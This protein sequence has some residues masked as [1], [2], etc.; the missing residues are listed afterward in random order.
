MT[1]LKFFCSAII[2]VAIAASV[3]LER[4]TQTK[5]RENEAVLRQQDH[6]F[7][8]LA[9]ENQRLYQRLSDLIAQSKTNRAP[10]VDR[11]TELVQLRAKV[12]ALRIQANQLAK[13][14]AENRRLTG[15]QYLSLGQSNLPGHIHILADSMAMASFR[16]NGK[17]NDASALA[18]A[19]LRYTDANQGVFPLNLNQVEPYLAKASGA[20]SPLTGTNDFEVAFQGSQN[21]LTNI[22]PHTVA[23][24]RERQ[25]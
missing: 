5:F 25:P 14:V 10:A 6:Q 24:I 11:T 20:N 22:P 7:A 3:L 18:A 13:R 21:D 4:R 23:L 17:L 8:G 1:K 9:A 19:L 16:A 15:A 2:I 12:E